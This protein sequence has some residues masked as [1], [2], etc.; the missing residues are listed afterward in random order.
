MNKFNL[1]CLIVLM[2]F[3]IVT[4]GC[5]IQRERTPQPPCPGQEPI[6]GAWIYDPAGRG[7]AVFLYIF[8]DYSRYDA[9]AIPRDENHPL[10]YE[11]WASGSWK[12]GTT[13]T[14]TLAGQVLSHDFT[15]DDLREGPNNETLTYDPARDILFNENHPRGIFT[16]IS[17][18]PQI[19]EGVNASIPFD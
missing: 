18:V 7:D 3:C 8:K 14:Y 16:R 15:T 10:A 2:L 5:V 4:A 1:A 12:R 17:C 13:Y 9:V 19:P 11:L 6:V